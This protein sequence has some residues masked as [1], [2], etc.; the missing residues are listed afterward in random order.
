MTQI[1]DEEWQKM[2]VEERQEHQIKNCIF[3]KIAKGEIHSNKIYD[4][5][6]FVGILDIK[7]STKGHVLVIPKKHVQIMPQLGT[8]LNGKLGITL[9]NISTKITKTLDAKATS[10]FIANGAVA[11]QIAPHL[12]IHV[13]PRKENDEVNLNPELNKA[14]K[15]K[16]LE[17][18][19]KIISSLGLPEP[20][21]ENQKQKT[22]QQPQP[23][24]KEQS[25]K[26]EET[27]EK[28]EEQQPQPE[29]KEQPEE[30]KIDKNLLDKI[31]DMF[32]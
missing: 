29:E 31:K 27:K 15:D 17:I 28:T 12:I 16:S 14:N 10:V 2:S 20:G 18:R 3:C 32:D 24:E 9:K 8:E 7:P 13:I 11:G 23:E 25:I 21:E 6:D 5:S 4:D 22:E 30:T 19:N 26:Q 1:T